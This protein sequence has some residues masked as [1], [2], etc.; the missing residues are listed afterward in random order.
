MCRGNGGTRLAD[1]AAALEPNDTLPKHAPITFATYNICNGR[2]SRLEMALRAAREMQLDFGLLTEVK[3]TEG[4]YTRSCEG[5]AVTATDAAS[6]HQGGV[7][8]FY[9]ESEYWQ[10]ESVVKHG[11]NVISFELVSGWRRTPVVGGYIPPTD[12]TTLPHMI[13]AMDRFSTHSA[14]N[15]ML[16]I[17]DF[18]VDL[19]DPNQDA[20]GSEII[21]A[22]ST[23][24]LEDL[25]LHFKP[26]ER[27]SHRQTWWQERGGFTIRSRCDYILGSDRR[28]F[29][30]ISLKDPRC[31]T[32]DHLMVVGRI[33]SA[34][35]SKNRSYLRSRT[36]YPLGPPRSGP[37]T[38]VDSIFQEL[39]NEVDPPPPRQ[40]NYRSWISDSTWKLVDARASLRRESPFNRT[41]YRQKDREV[42]AAIKADRTKRVDDA[43][44][45]I[46][47]LLK[48]SNVQGAWNRAKAWYK[49]AGDRPV[50]P[51]KADLQQVSEEYRDLYRKVDPPGDPI[52]ILVA[53]FDVCDDVPQ[54]AEIEAAVKRCKSGKAPGPT[55]M[56]AEDL[57]AWLH[58]ARCKERPDD[59]YWNLLVKL[60]QEVFRTGVLPTE[61]PRSI[62]VLLPKDSGGFRGIGL[63]E[64]I[65]KL[66]SSIIDA[67][68]KSSIEFHDCLHGFLAKRG[69][70]T[71][72]I[73]AKL[74]QQ[75]AALDQVP[76]FEIFLDLK[77]AYD[78][79]DRGRMLQ[80]LE[81]YGVGPRVL[82]LLRAFWDQQKVV[83]RQG[84]YYG[85][86]FDAD[87]GVT[88]GDIPS[89][90]EFNIVCDAVIRAWLHATCDDGTIVTSGFGV[91]VVE[92]GALFYAD[93]GLLGARDHEWLQKAIDVLVD[94][95]MRVGLHTNTTKTQTMTCTPGYI[96]TH[97]SSST[98]RRRI[99]GGGES[100]RE[101]QRRRVE[102][103]E[104][105]KSLAES[106]L[107][108]HSLSQH[109]IVTFPPV[110]AG[111]PQHPPAEYRI[112]F[113][114]TVKHRACPVEGCG[115]LATSHVK[116]RTHFAHRHPTD[117]IV[118]LEE[119]TAPLP[120]CELCDMHVGHYAIGDGHQRTA[121][122]KKLADAKRRR[123]VLEDIRRA[124]EVVFTACG[125]PLE[126]VRTFKYLGRV[127]SDTDNDG[128]AVY[129]NLAKARK[130]W[131]MFSRVLRREN[132]RPKVAA[133][134]YKATV[135]AVLLFGSETWVVSPPMLKA[136]TGFHHRVARQLTGKV[137]RYLPREDRWVYPPIDEVLAE[138]G[139]FPLE[140][141]IRRRQDRIVDYV[142]TR[143]IRHH[144]WD[145]ER[146]GGSSRWSTWWDHV[147]YRDDEEDSDIDD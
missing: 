124:E 31:F 7:A 94:L 91:R 107:P 105:G 54:E 47:T 78:T 135:Q 86:P 77:K 69:T 42:K 109:G 103:P 112:S 75:L 34:T 140:T 2:N 90:T 35:R 14:G 49:H 126:R 37:L 122:C 125:Q 19:S 48:D 13:A 104:C 95:F 41:A 85:N 115:N 139:L 79:L 82:T 59:T 11:P 89:P 15:R 33:T 123:H 51:S 119:G 84:R 134:F 36:R 23:H 129:K 8:L 141:Y 39:K 52:P 58:A 101:R 99:G 136:L 3:M 98:Y 114:R 71:A 10:I 1:L 116:M 46:D 147:G 111:V 32:S 121:M 106:S 6:K 50:A 144:F 120:R 142:S 18:N 70:G 61:L 145:R 133:M 44:E 97:Q 108:Q 96:R 26:R 27:Y 56:R 92:K 63:L 22:M 4:I 74:M 5:Y 62:L 76:L 9:R 29:S 83:A 68:L 28:M 102:C 131:G 81:A 20:R 55:G 117:V 30:N 143:P 66:I 132:C 100:Y 73:E 60:V 93:D 64:I 38:Q 40:R 128:P 113:P 53:P 45:A 16:V 67:R 88:Q 138:A 65:W 12:R 21:D 17:G 110:S 43:A 87:R 118:I 127:L 25:L 146:L 137:G 130:R 24:G 72:T 80:I 57:K